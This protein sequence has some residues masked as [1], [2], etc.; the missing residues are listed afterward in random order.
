MT[1]HLHIFT[2]VLNIFAPIY[3]CTGQSAKK[4]EGTL[5]IN[6]NFVKLGIIL[7]QKAVFSHY[8]AK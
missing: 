2:Y 1:P 8:N 6:I 5:L 4:I 3:F 7:E